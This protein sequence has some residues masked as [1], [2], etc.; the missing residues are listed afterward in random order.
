MKMTKYWMKRQQ[1]QIDNL[2]DKTVAETD[3]ELAAQYKKT[4]K[5]LRN[6]IA[7]LYDQI[8][9]EDD[10]LHTHLYQYDKYWEMKNEIQAELNHLGLKESEIFPKKFTEMYENNKKIVGDQ[11]GFTKANPDRVKEV[12]N[13]VWCADGKHWSSRI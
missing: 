9:A 8:M 2:F 6:D 7:S 5:K 3:A 12:L 11:F 4:L 10:P 1:E 13:S